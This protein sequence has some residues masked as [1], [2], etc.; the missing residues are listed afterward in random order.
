MD[1]VEYL[2]D[3]KSMFQA[4]NPFHMQ[5]LSAPSVVRALAARGFE[6]VFLAH[7]DRIHMVCL[8]RKASPA[9]TEMP[10][11][12]RKRRLRQYTAVRDL[13][14]LGLPDHRR[15]PFAA[16]WTGV[17]ERAVMSGMA[18]LDERGRVQFLGGRKRPD[19]PDPT[20]DLDA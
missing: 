12:E 9:K 2:S 15:E 3:G 4:M 19:D 20:G 7:S 8:A 11:S 14:I 13:S 16:E 6:V 5:I 10:E 1:E 18:T 17:V